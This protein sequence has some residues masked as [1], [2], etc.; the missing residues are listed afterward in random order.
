R[1]TKAGRSAVPRGVSTRDKKRE[2]RAR[3]LLTWGAAVLGLLLLPVTLAVEENLGLW[4]LFKLRGALPPPEDIIV[5][6]IDERSEAALGE[7][8]RR[9]MHAELVAALASGG[10]AVVVFDLFLHDES[11]DDDEF[12]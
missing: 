4:V 12:A 10:A 9:S 6:G 2:A 5:I 11:Q 3:R 8:I 1:I 7:P